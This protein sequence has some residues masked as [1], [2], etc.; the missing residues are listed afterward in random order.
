MKKFIKSFIK[1]D[2]NKKAEHFIKA[3]NMNSADDEYD[4]REQEEEGKA[5]ADFYKEQ[6][7]ANADYM[8]RKQ[9]PKLEKSFSKEEIQFINDKWEL[10]YSFENLVQK[11]NQYKGIKI[12]VFHYEKLYRF[13]FLG[14]TLV[15]LFLAQLEEM[16][17]IFSYI[18][19]LLV[20][21][22][23]VVIISQANK[24]IKL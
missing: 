1:N 22:N 23:M 12:T 17:R 20:A 9:Y 18:T 7:I 24:I 4:K 3:N 14:M 16:P 10:S 8:I 5:Q 13:L 15:C 11:P 2:Q 6:G 19:L 21:V